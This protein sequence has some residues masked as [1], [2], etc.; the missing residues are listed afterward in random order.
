M[1]TLSAEEEIGS[2]LRLGVL[3][4]IERSK[5]ILIPYNILS[6]RPLDI[7]SNAISYSYL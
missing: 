5:T 7:K 2:D 4:L 1:S 3:S 6:F